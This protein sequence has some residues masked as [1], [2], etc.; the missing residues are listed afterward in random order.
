MGQSIFDI[1][2]SAMRAQTLRLNTT[3]S[4]LANASSVASTPEEAY[5]ARHPVFAAVLD[6]ELGGVETRGVVESTREPEMRYEPGHPLANDEG[7][8]YGSN[9]D[10]VEEMANMMSAS[11]GY[12]SNVDMI[13]TVRQLML[14]T[15]KM[16]DS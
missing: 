14:Q 13:S 2:G 11:R 4:N 8:I 1:A 15:L 10:N 3:A 12:Q 9:V 5:R 7:Y 16:G 6:N